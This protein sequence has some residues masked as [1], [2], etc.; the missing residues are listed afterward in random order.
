MTKVYASIFFLGRQ[1]HGVECQS[2]RSTEVTRKKL[3]SWKSREHVPQ[4]PIAG[5]LNDGKK[6]LNLD[7]QYAARSL[8]E[9]SVGV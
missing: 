3:N 8:K 1:P 6:Q 2:L 5:D 4:C 7:E 9:H